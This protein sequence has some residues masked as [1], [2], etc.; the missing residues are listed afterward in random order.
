MAIRLGA[1]PDIEASDIALQTESRKTEEALPTVFFQAL[2][3]YFD[4]V[5]N[6]VGCDGSL[7]D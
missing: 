4:D 1:I 7:L 6:H 2:A 3:I 5:N